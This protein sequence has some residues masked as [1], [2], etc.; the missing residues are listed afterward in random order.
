MRTRRMPAGN[1]ATGLDMPDIGTTQYDPIEPVTGPRRVLGTRDAFALWFSLGIGL[2]VLQTGAL[3]APGLGFGASMGAIL[4]G[5]LIGVALLAAA[6]VIGADTGLSAMGTLRPALGVRGATLAALL[7]AI[8]LLGWSAFEIIAMRDA[9]TA[10]EQRWFGAAHPALLTL[11]FG[12]IGTAMAVAGPL[13][14]VRRFLRRSGFALIVLAALLFT[15]VLLTDPR[16]PRAFA[17]T[18][19]GSLTFGAAVDLIVTLP[20]SWLPLIADYTRFGQSAR[21]MGRGAFIGNGIG[22]FWFC[23]MGAAFAFIGGG[24]ALLLPAL[25]AS[26]AGL[27]LLLILVDETENAFAD[28]H[29]AS[30]SSRLFA[31][32]LPGGVGVL[33]VVVGTVS[34]LIALALPLAR[35]QGFLTLLGSVF[36]PLFGV[37]IADHFWLRRREIDLVGLL[38]RGGPYWFTGGWRIPALL[39]WAL[40]IACY[41]AIAQ[42]RPE[43]GATIPACLVAA[44]AH[45]GFAR[46]GARR[47]PG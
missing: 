27:P 3:L 39:A 43:W 12:A 34:T 33:S 47:G 2:L 21:A 45:A 14:I 8:Q 36:A 32:R 37:L 17:Q 26:L 9:A 23:A 6:G 10:L 16:L 15:A 30:V 22:N 44:L 35:Y 13:S 25:A 29:S 11:A 38:R 18:G 31:P 46:I 20:I 24:N 42:G 40:G 28:I 4:A 5:T 1:G 41:Q 19:D 7:N